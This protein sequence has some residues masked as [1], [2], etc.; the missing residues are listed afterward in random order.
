MQ[1]INLS[2]QKCTNAE[3]LKKF[4]SDIFVLIAYSQNKMQGKT[5]Q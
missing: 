1:A 4:T 3:Y 5:I 2:P